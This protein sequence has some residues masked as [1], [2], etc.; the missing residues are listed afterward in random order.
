M[1]FSTAEVGDLV[2][3]GRRREPSPLRAGRAVRH[4]P[5]RRRAGDRASRTRSRTGCGSSTSSTSSGC[6][7]SRAAG[8]ARTRARPSSSG[9]R[10]S[11]TLKHADADGV[12]DDAQGGRA[13]RIGA[14]VLRDLLGRGHRGRLP[15]RQGVGPPRHR[16]APHG[17][18]R[19]RGDGPRLDRVPARAGPPGV[20]RRRA[21]L[22]RLPERPGVRARRAGLGRGGG[23]RASGP[24]RHERRHAA[25]RGRARRR[26][27]AASGSTR[28]SGST[29]TTTP[30]ARSPT[31]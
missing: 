23:R 18:G 30:A 29:C 6:R 11:E 21:L 13:R 31:R 27:G 19:G 26:R 3:E 22:R 8:R 9:S 14:P 10:P 20:L 24:V 28:R 1:G 4:H 5:A 15:R 7:S 2:V 25:E 17:P 16:G 12:R